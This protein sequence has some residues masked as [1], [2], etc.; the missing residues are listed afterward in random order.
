MGDR[1]CS[2]ARELRARC[3]GDDGSSDGGN[4]TG[5]DLAEMAQPM[6]DAPDCP[7][8]GESGTTALLEGCLSTTADTFD[9]V[10]VVAYDA[11]AVLQWEGGWGRGRPVDASPAPAMADRFLR[12]MQTAT[13]EAR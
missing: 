13:P 1:V 8:P 2:S 9:L 6:A 12:A 4:G 3:G 10:V 11:C 5:V 7:A